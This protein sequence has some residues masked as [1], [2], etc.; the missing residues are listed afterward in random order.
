MKMKMIQF[1]DKVILTFFK[2]IMLLLVNQLIGHPPKEKLK[3][4]L[5]ETQVAT[6]TTTHVL[7]LQ[8]RIATVGGK[9]N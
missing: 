3:T 2:M 4:V 6:G 7:L 9:L 8:T 5:M 1:I